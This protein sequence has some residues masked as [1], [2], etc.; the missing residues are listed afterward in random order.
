MSLSDLTDFPKLSPL[1]LPVPVFLPDPTVKVMEERIHPD[2]LEEELN[3]KSERKKVQDEKN[4]REHRVVT[5]EGRR[6]EVHA[7]K[8][9]ALDEREGKG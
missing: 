5:K 3:F 2:P 6:R 4:K 7:P 1:Q 9:K 8:G